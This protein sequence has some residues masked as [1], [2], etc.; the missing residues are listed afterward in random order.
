[1]SRRLLH[2]RDHPGALD[3]HA[4]AVGCGKMTRAVRGKDGAISR[5]LGIDTARVCS[6]PM[7][8]AKAARIRAALKAR[9][10]LPKED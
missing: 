2:Y 7:S 9:G 3:Q 10:W 5:T 1:M 4:R 6:L 8:P